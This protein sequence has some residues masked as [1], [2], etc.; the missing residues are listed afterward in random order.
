MAPDL[1]AAEL[2]R[3]WEWHALRRQGATWPEL[4]AVI[5]WPRSRLYS[6]CGRIADALIDNELSSPPHRFGEGEENSDEQFAAWNAYFAERKAR[7]DALMNP[8][9]SR[10]RIERLPPSP[11]VRTELVANGVKPG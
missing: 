3:F 4:A 1:T 5:G 10:Q 6:W 11:V 2:A 7:W 8:A 9:K